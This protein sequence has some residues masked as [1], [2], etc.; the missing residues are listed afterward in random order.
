MSTT[1]ITYY[2]RLAPGDTAA[3]P[4]GLVRRRHTA[5][6]PTDEALRDDGR[7]H[8]TD[9]VERSAAGD[10]DDSLVEIPAEAAERIAERWRSI[11]ARQQEQLAAQ[12]RGEFGLRLAAA[13]TPAA[14]DRPAGAS[15]LSGAERVLVEAY[16]AGAPVV[17]AAWGFGPDPLAGGDA[18]VPLHIHTDGLWVWSESL[19]YYAGRYGIAPDPDLLAHIRSRRYRY[20]E[21]TAEVIERAGRLAAG[22]AT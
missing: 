7:W 17:V 3:D 15:A 6:Y 10:L 20:P 22:G 16:L 5:V 9:M 14:T 21:V 11:A 18:R 8:P 12:G 1:D 2:A 4:S 19:A 13:D